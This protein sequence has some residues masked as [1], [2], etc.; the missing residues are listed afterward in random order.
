MLCLP[1]GNAARARAFGGQVGVLSNIVALVS[2]AQIVVFFTT[3]FYL[4]RANLLS[5]L[6]VSGIDSVGIHG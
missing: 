1:Y 4:L 2:I 5:F 3:A 6:A